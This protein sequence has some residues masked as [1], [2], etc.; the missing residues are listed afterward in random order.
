MHDPSIQ[1]DHIAIGI[2]YLK[3]EYGSR[4][5]GAVGADKEAGGRKVTGEGCLVT[6]PFSESDSYTVNLSFGPS[7][8]R[9][10][11]LKSE[12]LTYFF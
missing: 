12:K 9:H 10:I 8:F 2:L 4:R 11:F 5:I 7:F 6:F 3:L 1:K